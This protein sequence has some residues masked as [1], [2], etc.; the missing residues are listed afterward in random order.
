MIKISVRAATEPARKFEPGYI[1]TM[2]SG[3]ML[4]IIAPKEQV[5]IN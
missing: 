1:S 4:L 5:A 2:I 3:R